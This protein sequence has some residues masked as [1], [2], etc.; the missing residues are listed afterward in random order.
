M[1]KDGIFA[2]VLVVCV[3]GEL[4]TNLSSNTWHFLTGMAL[5]TGWANGQ[6]IS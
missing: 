3:V 4:V 1:T 6:D 5:I 2:L